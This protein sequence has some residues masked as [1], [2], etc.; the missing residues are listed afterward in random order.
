MSAFYQDPGML[1]SI[2]M[3][4]N[5]VHDSQSHLVCM[6]P[7]VRYKGGFAYPPDARD[8]GKPRLTRE[9]FQRRRAELMATRQFL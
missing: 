5:R 9:E 6:D 7:H 8:K 1:P 2:R 4:A 3:A